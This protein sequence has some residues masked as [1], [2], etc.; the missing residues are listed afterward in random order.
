[1][2]RLFGPLALGLATVLAACGGS[3]APASSPAAPATSTAAAP[4]SAA[5]G[6]SAKPAGSAAAKPAGCGAASGAASADSL[7]A[8]KAEA[9]KNGGKVVWYESI[10]QDQGEKVLDAFKQDYPFMTGA[11]FVSVVS[12]QQRFAQAEALV[13]WAHGKDGQVVVRHPLRM[14]GL[15]LF[16]EQPE[17][18]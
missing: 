12:G 3:A 5:A 4:A 10:E 6:A 2:K 9:Q 7:D 15:E 11:K 17:A 8:V 16:V 1:M 18:V 14:V 13:V